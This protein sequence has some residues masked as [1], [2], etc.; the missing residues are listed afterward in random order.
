[1]K[2][3]FAMIREQISAWGLAYTVWFYVSSFAAVALFML[4]ILFI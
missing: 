2:L 1:M 3:I 4:T